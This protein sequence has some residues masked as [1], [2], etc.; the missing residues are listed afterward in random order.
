MY[1]AAGRSNRGSKG[2]GLGLGIADGLSGGWRRS[3]IE[4]V[5]I[6]ANI[7]IADGVCMIHLGKVPVVVAL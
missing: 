3:E 2:L 6:W 7:H 5:D 4:R 1:T